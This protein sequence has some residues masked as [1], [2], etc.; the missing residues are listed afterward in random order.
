MVNCLEDER[1]SFARC[2]CRFETEEKDRC[3]FYM[4]SHGS[5]TGF[6]LAGQGELKASVFASI[7]DQMCGARDPPSFWFFSLLLRY[8]QQRLQ[9]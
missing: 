5:R 8:F 6:Y 9:R 1:K 7:L 4:T 3:L 2:H